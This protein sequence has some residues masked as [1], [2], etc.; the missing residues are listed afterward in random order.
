MEYKEKVA[1]VERV[2]KDL[3]SGKSIDTIKSDLQAEG[4]YEYD[5]NNVIASARKTLSEPYKQ[6]IK[7]YLLNDQEILNSDEFANVD[8][9]T[10]QQ[11]VDQERRILNLQERKKITKLIKDGQS[12]EIALK[13]IDQRFLSIEEASEQIEKDQNTLQKNS[14]SGKL[15]IAIKIALFLYLSVHFYN[16]NNHVSILSF[17]FAVVNIFKALKTE[18]LDYE[19]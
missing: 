10:L 17:I 1:Y 8:K 9:D 3:E 5:I 4:L 7:N 16:V 18:K 12:K 19:E 2:T 13:S 15:F 6:T 14:I 11:M